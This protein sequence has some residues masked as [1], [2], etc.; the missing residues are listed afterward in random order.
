MCHLNVHQWKALCIPH[1]LIYTFL[2]IISICF[3]ILTILFASLYHNSNRS[4]IVYAVEKGIIGFPVR[5]PN[6]GRYVQWTFLH[7]NDV[8]E[9]LPLHSGRKGGLARVAYIRKLLKQENSHTYTI[10]A[11]D[12]L[13]PSAL[14]TSKINGTTLNGRQMID[15]FNTLGLDFTTFGNHEF[16]LDEKDLLLRMNESKFS[17]ISTNIYRINSTQLFGTSIS[18]KILI[19]NKVRI[20]IIG[21]TIDK[22]QGYVKIINQTYLITHVQQYLQQ[23]SSQTYDIL[24]AITHL[25]MSLDIKL[26]EKIP[27]IDLILGGHEHEDYY[28]LR[29]SKYTSIYK[30]DANAFTVYILRCAY[31]ID[32]KK[33]RIYPTLT[34]VT[35]EVPEEEQTSKVANY[36]FNLG[37]EGFRTSGFEPNET[38][39][40]LPLGLELDGRYESVKTSSTL[41]TDLICQSMI[42]ATE[43]SRTTVALFNGGAIRIDDILRETITQYDI[44]RTLPFK[45]IIIILS[46]PGKLLARILTT[47]TSMKRAG[48]I[49]AYAGVETLNNGET[50]LVNGM[51]I[52]TSGL[53]Y[54]V[55]TIEYTKLRTEL[56]HPDVTV[57][58]KTNLTQAKILIDYLKIKYPPC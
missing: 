47:G 5:L 55:A 30:A 14:S 49:L 45:N 27:Q 10:L 25:D 26:A 16:D 53:N 43:S 51:D 38:V 2:S 13:S 34:P 39:S 46:V 40:C 24:V 41:L 37:I 12:F 22:N 9:L 11:G 50:W 31:N 8:Y 54:T 58:Q 48:S 33:F 29:G 32:T 4:S 20:L 36:W 44:I 42:K 23:F 17:W 28:Y 1:G 35:P 6:D 56:N 19:I 21:L 57:L 52:S 18:H 3:L 15:T 7:L